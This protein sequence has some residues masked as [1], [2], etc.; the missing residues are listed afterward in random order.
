MSAAHPPVRGS[1]P[2]EWPLRRHARWRVRI[3][4][5]KRERVTRCRLRN[6]GVVRDEFKR[7]KQRRKCPSHELRR[8]STHSSSATA[9]DSS[10]PPPSK[11]H[12]LFHSHSLP[13]GTRRL[14]AS[15]TVQRNKR[16][17]KSELST[18]RNKTTTKTYHPSTNTTTQHT[19]ECDTRHMFLLSERDIR[20]GERE[21]ETTTEG[22]RE[23]KINAERQGR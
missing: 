10:L 20:R 3:R 22:E 23:G 9:S 16:M 15:C 8:Q 14:S 17:R 2:P 19:K 1:Q 12:F 18:T 6:V 7:H 5:T 11:S 13:S 4:Q 21:K